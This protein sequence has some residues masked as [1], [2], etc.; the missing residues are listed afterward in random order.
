MET[1]WGFL[2][3]VSVW[4]LRDGKRVPLFPIEIHCQV[5]HTNGDCYD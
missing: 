2:I 5:C 4:V 3:S 1:L